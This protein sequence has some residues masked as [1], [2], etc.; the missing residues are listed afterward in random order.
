MKKL[1]AIF[2]MCSILACS[3]DE[4]SSNDQPNAVEQF[5]LTVRAN[6]G[7]TVSSS[8]GTYNEGTEVTLTATPDAEFLFVNW[9]NGSTTNPLKI[10]VNSDVELAA[11]FEKRKY[12][13]T[14]QVEGEGTVKEEIIN[15]GKTTTEYT[16]GSTIRLT[17]EPN[18]E[19]VFV[20]WNGSVEGTENPIEITVDEAKELIATFEKRKYPLI[21]NI[22]GEGTVKEEIVNAGKTTTEYT[23]GSTIRLTADPTDGWQFDKWTEDLETDLNPIEIVVNDSLEV[24]ANFIEIP[25]NY[26]INIVGSGNFEFEWEGVNQK[27]T[28]MAA[29]GWRFKNWT[30]DVESLIN[31]ITIDPTEQLQITLTFVEVNSDDLSSLFPN[32]DY[33]LLVNALNTLQTG[34][35]QVQV[36]T[37]NDIFFRNTNLGQ[38]VWNRFFEEYFSNNYLTEDLFNYLQLPSFFWFDT[39][40]H[41]ILQEAI[42]KGLLLHLGTENPIT[43]IELKTEPYKFLSM[44]MFRL[45]ANPINGEVLRTDVFNFYATYVEAYPEFLKLSSTITSDEQRLLPIRFQLAAAFSHYARL[46]P[47]VKDQITDILDI[48]GTVQSEYKMRIWN[49]HSI[50]AIDNNF[51]NSQTLAVYEDVLDIINNTYHSNVIFT[52]FDTTMIPLDIAMQ[53]YFN[54]FPLQVGDIPEN[55]FPDD[56]D[57][58]FA[59]VT[60]LVFQHEANHGTDFYYI[61]RWTPELK[62]YKDLILSQAGNDRNNYLRSMFEDGFFQTFP[63]EFFASI[64]NMYFANTKLTFQVALERYNNGIVHPLN[65]FLLIANVYSDNDSMYLFNNDNNLFNVSEV[66]ITKGASGFIDSIELN[67]NTYNFELNSD[68]TV[69]A[70]TIE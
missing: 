10:T 18:D 45:E 8:G 5:Q 21:V 60:F 22:E 26:E 53:G 54:T 59:D 19:W 57:P 42:M 50:L 41:S 52:G 48:D 7:G 2:C 47:G 55:G 29:E 16:S 68:N 69:N 12:A 17:A 67:G 58:Y 34:W 38:D 35:V 40:M 63:Q 65:Q 15:A 14:I 4:S 23:S 31:F 11:N 61:D 24:T 49:N 28:A 56:V 44:F 9:S 39:T 64:S 32:N 51:F 62:S 46:N 43:N 3:N 37:A 70:M 13:L 20:S 30:G 27:I 1:I 66:N 6:E 33:E 25:I 36:D